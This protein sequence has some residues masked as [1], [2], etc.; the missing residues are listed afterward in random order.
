MQLAVFIDNFSPVVNH[1]RRIKKTIAFFLGNRTAKN[2]HTML[3]CFFNQKPGAAALPQILR[4]LRQMRQII[5]HIPKL[6]QHRQ[7]GAA[8]RAFVQQSGNNRFIMLNLARAHV[9]L[10]QGRTQR[11]VIKIFLQ[12]IHPPLNFS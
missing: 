10:Q 5:A 11:M 12:N 1:Q 3:P 2:I 4:Q 6:R 9:K 8:G 7:L